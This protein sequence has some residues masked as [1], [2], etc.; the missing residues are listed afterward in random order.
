MITV[1]AGGVGAARF[2]AGLVQVRPAAEIT[3]IVN[4]GDDVVLHGLHIS[5][6]LDTVTYTLAGAID[7]ETGLGPRRRD[8][9]AP[10]RRC[11]AR[12]SGRR[13][14]PRGSTSA[15]ATS[16]PT[17]TAPTASAEGASLTEVTAEIA[18]AW[19][20]GAPPAARHRRPA[21]QTRVTVGRRGRDRLP[22]VLRRARSTTWP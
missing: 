17:S 4:V 16:A 15:T 19:G 5:P 21:S 3:A 11:S 2:L 9:A 22:G 20:L 8:V 1:L 18:A 13:R 7:P 10:W 12:V 6:D 14:R